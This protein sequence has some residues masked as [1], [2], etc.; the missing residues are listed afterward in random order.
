MPEQKCLFVEVTEW[1]AHQIGLPF[2]FGSWVISRYRIRSDRVTKTQEL[3]RE[4]GEVF[5]VQRRQEAEQKLS[6][7]KDQ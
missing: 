3:Y 6:E 7:I 5:R 4:D 1:R 2:G